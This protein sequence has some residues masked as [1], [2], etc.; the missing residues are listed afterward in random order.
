MALGPNLALLL[1]PIK[2]YWSTDMPICSHIVTGC[3]CATTAETPSCNTDSTARKAENIYSLA[4]YR[5]SSLLCLQPNSPLQFL[6]KG[7][8][9]TYLQ[10]SKF[11][12]KSGVHDYVHL[13]AK[14]VQTISPG[15]VLSRTCGRWMP[16]AVPVT[17]QPVCGLICHL[18]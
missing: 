7:L 17:T 9:F 10:F 8:D 5:K 14:G 3:F 4:F 15:S 2:F 11:F 12:L 6:A 16:K 13:P 1:V 18:D